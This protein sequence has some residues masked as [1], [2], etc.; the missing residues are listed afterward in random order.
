M[1]STKRS[2]SGRCQSLTAI[3]VKAASR[4]SSTVSDGMRVLRMLM[5]LFRD[6]RPMRFFGIAS[7]LLLVTSAAT[8]LVPLE[9][10]LATGLVTRFPTLIVSVAL[11]LGATLS[12]ACGVLLDSI[13][14]HS[15][16]S[17]ELERNR[18]AEADRRAGECRTLAREAD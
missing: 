14:A 13:R 3:A 8:F 4:S 5:Q 15:L 11:G 7:A 16:Q 18:F 17:F 12:F 2:S 10:Y 1:R 9:E 6:Y